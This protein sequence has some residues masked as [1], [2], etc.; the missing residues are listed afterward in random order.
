MTAVMVVG[1]I[2]EANAN[3]SPVTQSNINTKVSCVDLTV[4]QVVELYEVKALN[5]AN[6]LGLSSG[7]VLVIEVEDNVQVILE[8]GKITVFDLASYHPNYTCGS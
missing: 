8:V 7:R 3:I 6:A 5:D 2:Y 4:R 1:F